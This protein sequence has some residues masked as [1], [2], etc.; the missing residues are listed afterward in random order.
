MWL[1]I[2]KISDGWSYSMYQNDVILHS[3]LKWGVMGPILCALTLDFFWLK[4]SSVSFLKQRNGDKRAETSWAVL[5]SNSLFSWRFSGPYQ[6][7]L[8]LDG[9]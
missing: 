1:T 9:G 6:I 7:A 3:A 4:L 8:I 5:V 2:F